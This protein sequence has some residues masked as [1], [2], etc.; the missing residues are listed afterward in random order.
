M[1][2]NTS[3]RPRAVRSV[4]RD[5][6]KDAVCVG[7]RTQFVDADWDVVG[8]LCRLQHGVL[9][10]GWV[11]VYGGDGAVASRFVVYGGD[12]VVPCSIAI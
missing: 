12:G 8:M 9:A 3:L 10:S 4:T 6:V 7:E 2:G 5:R 11:M 1:Q